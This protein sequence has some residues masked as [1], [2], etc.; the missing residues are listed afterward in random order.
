MDGE[1][2]NETHG[3]RKKELRIQGKKGFCYFIRNQKTGKKKIGQKR[4]G[5]RKTGPNPIEKELERA[6]NPV[7]GQN[8]E[9]K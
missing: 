2:N 7:S 3:I 9:K 5:N 8:A 4:K 6:I 1:L